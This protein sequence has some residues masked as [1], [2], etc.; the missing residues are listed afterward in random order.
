M[1]KCGKSVDNSEIYEVLTEEMDEE[2]FAI[3]AERLEI[4]G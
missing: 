4:S 1:V 2:I 3:S